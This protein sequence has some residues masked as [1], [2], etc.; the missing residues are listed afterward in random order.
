MQQRRKQRKHRESTNLMS[1]T[2]NSPRSA[3][4]TRS[5]LINYE[6]WRGPQ[7]STTNFPLS[8]PSSFLM[9]SHIFTYFILD[10]EHLVDVQ[11]NVNFCFER[12]SRCR[13][14]AN[15]QVPKQIEETTPTEDEKRYRRS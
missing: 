7:H 14:R 10:P 15:A 8:F 12:Y 6:S 5:E 3:S 13:G 11:N 4:L 2:T 1:K 9:N